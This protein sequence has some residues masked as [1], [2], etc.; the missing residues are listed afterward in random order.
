MQLGIKWIFI[1]KS[2]T[3]PKFH[4]ETSLAPGKIAP[5]HGCVQHGGIPPCEEKLVSHHCIGHH[6]GLNHP[7]GGSPTAQALSSLRLNSPKR[8]AH[9][10]LCIDSTTGDLVR[11]LVGGGEGV[12]LLP[13]ALC[14][15]PQR[16][17]PPCR[18][19]AAC[20]SGMVSFGDCRC[21][22]RRCVASLSWDFTAMSAGTDWCSESSPCQMRSKPSPAWWRSRP[23]LWWSQ[24]RCPRKRSRGKPPFWPSMPMWRMRKNILFLTH[25]RL[26]ALKDN[27]Y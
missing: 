6:A 5:D 7:L 11:R 10:A 12:R 13:L 3:I 15:W 2:L 14:I 21:R 20:D 8:P 24:R 22:K 19:D 4:R 25:L 9:C 18:W 26:G 16:Q 23:R 27:V 17:L 1:S